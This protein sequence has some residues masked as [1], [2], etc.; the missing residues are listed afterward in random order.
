MIKRYV[1]EGSGRTGPKMRIGSAVMALAILLCVSFFG[2]G[3]V[4]GQSITF[5]GDADQGEG[6]RWMRSKVEQFAKETGIQVHYIARPVSTTGTLMLWQ[7]DWAAKTP[8]ID[9]YIVDVIWPRDRCSPC[10][11]DKGPARELPSFSDSR[12]K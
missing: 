5:A 7:Q 10:G 8:D 4:R 2:L 12:R 11:A 3:V 9:V 1:R 6:G